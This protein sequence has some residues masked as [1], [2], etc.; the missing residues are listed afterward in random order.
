MKFDFV[1]AHWNNPN[2]LKK[3]L[4][5]L[6]VDRDLDFRIVLV[7]NGSEPYLLEESIRH[8][9]SAGFNYLLMQRSNTNREAGAYWH[10]ILNLPENYADIILFTQ[11]E[12]HQK[13][14]VPKNL[15]T[16]K[17]YDL[18]NN[19][20]RFRLGFI[21]EVIKHIIN[22]PK[23]Y[24]YGY[25]YKDDYSVNKLNIIR[26]ADYLSKNPSNQVGLGGRKCFFCASEDKRF[27]HGHWGAY[28]AK[29]QIKNYD[30]FS[31]ACFAISSN[32]CSLVKDNFTPSE[33]DFKDPVF[34]WFWER[35]WGVCIRK[36]G[37]Q[38]VHYRDFSSD[39]YESFSSRNKINP[40]YSIRSVSTKINGPVL[41]D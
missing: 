24:E 12:L 4:S 15:K 13:G 31:G 1:V 10:Y 36:L 41:V 6:C 27:N 26:I 5:Y 30:F 33:S 3:T 29:H 16:E 38:L 20:F 39:V 14:M 32:M 35:M 40:E 8:I 9:E 28:L 11:E 34:A 37:G 17:I 22:I 23:V 19:R 2:A 18:V 7:D 25:F 21:K